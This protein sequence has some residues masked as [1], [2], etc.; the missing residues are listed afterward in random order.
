MVARYSG[1]A[2]EVNL[3]MIRIPLSL[4]PGELKTIKINAL[5]KENAAV[6]NGVDADELNVI[7]NE[8]LLLD[9]RDFGVRQDCEY[10]KRA[11]V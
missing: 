5:V 11:A 4:A 6:S 2:M 1:V 8:A 3:P 7:R 10:F 9:S